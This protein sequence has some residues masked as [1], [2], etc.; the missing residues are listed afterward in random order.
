MLVGHGDLQHVVA[1]NGFE[2]GG[3]FRGGGVAVFANGHLAR[4]FEFTPGEDIS[5]F[6]ITVGLDLERGRDLGQ[7]DYRRAGG[8]GVN[9][10]EVRLRPGRRSRGLD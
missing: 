6:H 9:A 4:A 10:L 8:D 5:A 1:G 3:G 2:S 7:G